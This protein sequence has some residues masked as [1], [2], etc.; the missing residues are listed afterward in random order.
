MPQFQSRFRRQY[1]ALTS[2]YVL[3]LFA[4]LPL[5]WNPTLKTPALVRILPLL[6]G[7]IVMLVLLSTWHRI[8][9]LEKR[10]VTTSGTIALCAVMLLGAALEAL[11]AVTAT[12]LLAGTQLLT[13][14]TAAWALAGV[15]YWRRYQG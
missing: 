9:E 6:P 15:I 11:H 3:G 7:L 1:I 4:I 2:A 13:L 8:D 14:A 12:P 5:L 10:I